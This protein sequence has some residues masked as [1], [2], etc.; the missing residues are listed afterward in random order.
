MTEPSPQHQTARGTLGEAFMAYP[1]MFLPL[2]FG[3]PAV[4]FSTASIRD[5]ATKL[6][7]HGHVTPVSGYIAPVLSGGLMLFLTV[8]CGL[9]LRAKARSY[10]AFGVLGLLFRIFRGL[11]TLHKVITVGIGLVFVQFFIAILLP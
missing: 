10:G 2:L 5:L 11:R 9:I 8:A 7:S 3:A 6:S 1:G 4:I